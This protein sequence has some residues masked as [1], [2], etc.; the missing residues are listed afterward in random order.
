M[1]DGFLVHVRACCVMSGCGMHV[2]AMSGH[3]NTCWVMLDIPGDVREF[4]GSLV[5]EV[6]VKASGRALSYAL[7]CRAC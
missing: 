5:S 4:L 2:G 1:P 7:V 3:S 6:P